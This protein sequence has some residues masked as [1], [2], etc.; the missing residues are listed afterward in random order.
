[1]PDSLVTLRIQRASHTK[2]KA[3]CDQ[4]GVTISGFLHLVIDRL[5]DDPTILFESDSYEDLE[6]SEMREPDLTAFFEVLEQ[7]DAAR[8]R[9]LAASRHAAALRRKQE[10]NKTLVGVMAELEGRRMKRHERAVEHNRVQARERWR[11]LAAEKRA[12]Q[13]KDSKPEE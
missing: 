6:E 5:T 3:L 1:M 8:K 12:A 10:Q 4:L 11:R 9:R 13:P 7:R 2:L